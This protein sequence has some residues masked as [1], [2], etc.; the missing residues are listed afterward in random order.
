[1]RR[2]IFER[3]AVVGTNG[4]LP[5]FC[6]TCNQSIDRSIDRCMRDLGERDLCP[7]KLITAPRTPLCSEIGAKELRRI[8]EAT[9]PAVIYDWQLYAITWRRFL[10]L[11]SCLY[12][13]AHWRTRGMCRT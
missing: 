12:I 8:A 13:A 7:R 6:L 5:S 1:M 2:S 3:I 10:K 11:S 9:R 4:P